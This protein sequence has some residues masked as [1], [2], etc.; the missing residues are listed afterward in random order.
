MAVWSGVALVK[1]F[2]HISKAEQR[3]RLQKR[4]DDPKKRWKFSTADL[5]ERELWDDYQRAYEDALTQ[6]NTPYAPWHIVPADHKWYRNLVVSRLLC[7]TL[8]VL[9]PRFPPAE[10]GLKGLTIK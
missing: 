9:D 7:E 2:L 8:Q 1:V 6:C 5:A 4:L 3:R 10:K